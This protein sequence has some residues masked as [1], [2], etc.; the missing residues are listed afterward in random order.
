MQ[1]LLLR[2]GALAFGFAVILGLNVVFGNLLT[3]VQ[4]ML[5]LCGIY[6][7]LAVS[8]NIVNGLTGQ[9][10]IGHAGFMAVGS[11]VGAAISY[12]M[13]IAAKEAMRHA[14]PGW[15]DAQALEAFR[16]ANWWLMPFGMVIAG[17][18]AALFGWMVGV[19]SF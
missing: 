8:L 9:F 7:I 16:A 13:W 19:P 10:S 12:P 5:I 15:S 6:V 3:S 18:V 4:D 1:R 11:Y 17:T 2:A 14:H